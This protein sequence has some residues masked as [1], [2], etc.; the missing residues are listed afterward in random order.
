M[1]A[2]VRCGPESSRI[3]EPHLQG[4]TDIYIKG[5]WSEHAKSLG[6]APWSSTY[7]PCQFCTLCKFELHSQYSTMRDD[8][9]WQLRTPDDYY[10]ACK[11]SEIHIPLKTPEDRRNLL[12]VLRW[13]KPSKSDPITGRV[14]VADARI[15]NVEV[16]AG[17][18]VEPSRAL[19]D[20]A[21]L[22][23]APLPLVVTLW[24]TKRHGKK[25]LD[26]VSHRCPIF[27]KTLGTS[28]AGNL[29]VDELHCLYFGPI[30]RYVSCVLWRVALSN[31]WR[32]AGD[33]D[34]VVELAV[35]QL[36][37]ELMSWQ[38]AHDV[39]F[40]NRLHSL[41]PKMLGKRHGFTIQDP[42]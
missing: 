41:T 3:S 33:T 25:S 1:D 17:D 8:M 13:R 11:K 2:V 9:Q 20:T 5:D 12:N 28:P 10:E 27:D 16:L 30:M 24:R 39:P 7:A 35:R 21:A 19:V 14:V 4:R 26:C 32:F 38:D 22:D 42:W 31:H 36:S 15:C 18:R 23:A 37:G 6:L 29:A 40:N 34:Q